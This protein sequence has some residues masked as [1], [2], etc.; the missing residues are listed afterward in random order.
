MGGKTATL[1]VKIVSDA[2]AAGRGMDDTANRADRMG[3]RLG[4]ASKVAAVGMLGLATAAVASA[5]AAAEDQKSQ[6]I[7]ANT[8][9][10]T[11]GATNAQVAA[12]EAFIDKTARASGVADD[13]LRPALGNLL[14]GTG[15]LATAQK[16][17]GVAMDVSAATG[18][19]LETVSNALAKA[20]AGN[21]GS[22]ARLVPSLDAATLKSGDMNK[23]MGELAKTTGGAA[24]E[25]AG[26]A[27]GQFAR[28]QVA[29]GEASEELGMVLIPALTK[30]AEILTAV[31]GWI[32]N[33]QT[34]TMILVGAFV[35]LAAITWIANAALAIHGV[36]T[37]RSAAAATANAAATGVSTAANTANTTS[38]LG[39]AAA[40]VRN[41]ALWVAQRVAMLANLVVMGAI[42]VATLAW[43]AAQWL[44]NAALL[45]N[46]LG[47]FIAA[48]L[49]VV[50]AIVLAY[51]NSETFRNIVQA[52]AK[53]CV[54]AFNWVVDKV[55]D[56]IRWFNGSS[57]TAKVVR[58]VVVGA[59]KAMTAPIRAVI[60]LVKSLVS[61]L[62]KLDLGKIGDA[63]GFDGGWGG[64]GDLAAAAAA[65]PGYAYSAFQ[66]GQGGHG[67]TGF[68]TRSGGSSAG[69]TVV[70]INITG[71]LDPDAVGRQ[72]ETILRQR[73][74]R[75]GRTI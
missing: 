34:T 33:N 58:T 24:A 48:I 26:T 36:L 65:T 3:R 32:Q 7:L 20:Y 1:V 27:E 71:A 75:M 18:K 10:N 70:Q 54:T 45:A 61:W 60:D 5:R 42:R 53:A 38:L 4:K 52:V 43:T 59:F 12:T 69:G 14:R 37:M 31:V 2:S 49:A 63:I 57:D 16:A 22:L 46:P 25:A 35:A 41:A 62:G 73:G 51:R 64:P 21:T 23:I 50:A 40:L 72:I 11:T 56:L 39:Q 13:Q 8:L 9:R 47:L 74:V 68:V 30:L 66:G 28:M 29:L 6:A 19:P 17:L 44:L 55:K 15:D 67:G